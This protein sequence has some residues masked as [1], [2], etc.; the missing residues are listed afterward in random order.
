MAGSKKETTILAAG[1]LALVMTAILALALR[2]ELFATQALATTVQVA[3]LGLIVWARRSLGKASFYPLAIPQRRGLVTLGPYARMRHP[4]Y[5]GLLALLWAGAWSSGS[6]M[7]FAL[8]SLATLGSFLRIA[9]EE[10]E[11]ARRFEGYD[12]Y[13]LRTNRLVPKLW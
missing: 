13:A 2:G 6:V 9:A 10:A 3:A 7:A 1:G 8:A 5:S 11:L 4:I 12:A